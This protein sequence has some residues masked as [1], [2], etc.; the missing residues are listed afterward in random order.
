LI[1]KKH[2]IAWERGFSRR[3]AL[4][5]RE[6]CVSQLCTVLQIGA[7]GADA[8]NE[9]PM[10]HLLGSSVTYRIAMGPKQGRKVFTL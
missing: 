5:L 10:N 7:S 1:S 3:F 2:V 8:D 4:M 9:V 6:L